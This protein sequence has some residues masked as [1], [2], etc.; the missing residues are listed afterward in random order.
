MSKIL[1]WYSFGVV[2]LT[3]V[4][5]VCGLITLISILRNRMK[6]EFKEKEK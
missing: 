4:G 6:S 1:F 3:I 5:W 2:C